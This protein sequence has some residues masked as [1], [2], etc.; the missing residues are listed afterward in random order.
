M[1]RLAP[2]CPLEDGVRRHA[3]SGYVYGSLGDPGEV[4][5]SGTMPKAFRQPL[6]P[7]SF[8]SVRFNSSVLVV[9]F[10]LSNASG[11][12]FRAVVQEL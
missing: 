12:T 4:F 3:V 8:G 9:V 11:G 5:P 7:G 1:A 10:S 2:S 6:A